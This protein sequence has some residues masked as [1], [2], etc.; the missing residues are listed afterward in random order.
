[1]DENLNNKKNG[2]HDNAQYAI[3]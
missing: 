3:Q 1:L 2:I